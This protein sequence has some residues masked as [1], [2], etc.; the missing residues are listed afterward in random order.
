[1]FSF[2][3]RPLVW[4]GLNVADSWRYP[5]ALVR[6]FLVNIKLPNFFSSFCITKIAV[7]KFDTLCVRFSAN[8][9]GV[10]S[11]KYRSVPR[12]YSIIG[13]QSPWTIIMLN[14]INILII[15]RVMETQEGVFTCAE[16]EE[17][18]EICW[19]NKCQ[20]LVQDAEGAST[21]KVSAPHVSLLNYV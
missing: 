14:C 20:Q 18:H 3:E 19:T 17:E 5:N 12:V 10:I 15:T 11:I 6:F 4:R 13:S 16:S 7:G 8:G 2:C 9:R 1:M 21:T